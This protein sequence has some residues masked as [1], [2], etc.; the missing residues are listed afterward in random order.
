MSLRGTTEADDLREA[1]VDLGP[2]ALV[3]DPVVVILDRDG[4]GARRRRTARQEAEQ[5]G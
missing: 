2:P 1:H 5:T 4:R 3:P